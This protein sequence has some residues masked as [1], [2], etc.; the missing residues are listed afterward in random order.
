M[1]EAAPCSGQPEEETGPA[2]AVDLTREDRESLEEAEAEARPVSYSGTDFD[3]EGIVRR[4][5]RGDIVIPRFGDESVEIETDRFQRSFVWRRPQ[6][7]R[8]IESLLLEYPIPGIILVQQLDKRYLVLDGQQRLNTLA[9]FYRGMHREREFSLVNV[10]DRFKGLTYETL[11]PELRRTL[12]NT[13]IQATIVKTDGSA[14]SLDAIYQVFE[15]LNSG[16]TQ[17]TPHE[18]RVALYAGGFIGL[19]GQLN[20]Q[21][22]WRKLYGNKSP[23]LRDQELVLRTLA[24]YVSAATYRRPLKTFLNDFVGEYREITKF[25]VDRIVQQFETAARLLEAGPGRRALRWAGNRAVN[26]ALAEAVFVGLMR[27]LDLGGT[28]PTPEA[29]A[30][31]VERFQGD[32]RLANAVTRATADEESVRTRLA[33][34]TREFASI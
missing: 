1:T 20:D 21:P 8:F 4:L 32:E 26:A 10:A 5:K 7:D 2:E 17:L 30:A 9:E 33:I 14:G 12:N 19:L 23:R 15:R 27:R 6:M 25:P 18:I 16:G 28:E 31:A 34:T 13:F 22:A 11:P 24:L 29:V 3:V